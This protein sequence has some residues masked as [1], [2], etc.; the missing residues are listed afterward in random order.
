MLELAVENEYFDV[1]RETCLTEIASSL[2]I[3]D[4]AASEWLRRGLE[5]ILGET[6]LT[7]RNSPDSQPSG[8]RGSPS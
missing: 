4:Q 5:N 2:G 1:P 6:E 8:Q 7:S 3:S